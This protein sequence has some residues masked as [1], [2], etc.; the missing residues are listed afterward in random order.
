MSTSN[1]S[2]ADPPSAPLG[3]DFTI[4]AQ[5]DNLNVNPGIG[6][7][8]QLFIFVVAMGA[9]VSRRPDAIFNPQFF[10]EDGPVWYGQAY[11]FGW[12]TAL[13]GQYA[14]YLQTLP[15]LAASIALLVPLQ[16]APLVMNLIGIVIHVLPVTVLLSSRCVN[17]APLS[18]R[19][20][21][22]AAYIALPNTAE[23]NS[24]I[25]NSQWH[26]AL[27]ASML[28]LAS[29]T[30]DPKWRIFDIASI[31]LSGLTGPFCILLL[32]VAIVYWWVRRERWRLVAVA[33]LTVTSIAQA[34]TIF[35]NSAATRPKVGLGATPELFTRLLA[36][37]VY[38]GAVLGH[39]GSPTHTNLALLASVAVL[40]TAVLV[41][42]FIKAGLELK[43]F[44]LFAELVFAASLRSPMVSMTVPQWQVLRDAAG[45]RYFFFPMLAFVWAMIWCVGVNQLV[46]VRIAAAV[47]L[48]CMLI[49]IRR[50]WRSPAYTNFHF[51]EHAREFENAAPGT[52][53][54]IPIYPPGWTLRIT[55]KK[56]DCSTV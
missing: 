42:C 23:L 29:V 8:L 28:V 6:W 45:I 55:K 44:I 40:G 5:S 19:A 2:S 54:S 18:T 51:Q 20:L 36:G 35:L 41:Y 46:S 27:L 48:A 31:L 7:K 56:P 24:S 11:A 21:M 12:L 9:I 32:P 33:I 37:Q 38:M 1:P 34:A 43:L 30:A 17:W 53:M 26:L 25:T 13:T 3:A 10:G 15:R 16:F 49:G 4:R 22:A 52:F 39:H 14:G 50:D 47:G